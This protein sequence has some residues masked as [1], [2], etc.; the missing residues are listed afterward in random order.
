MSN[1]FVVTN[2]LENQIV[3]K[4]TS[5]NISGSKSTLKLTND[6]MEVKKLKEAAAKRHRRISE[7]TTENEESVYATQLGHGCIGRWVLG[8]NATIC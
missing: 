1:D 2:I 6:D 4:S 5:S 7:H 3:L 8:S